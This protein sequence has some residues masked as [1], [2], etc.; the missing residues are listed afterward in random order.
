MLSA[1]SPLTTLESPRR[2]RRQDRHQKANDPGSLERVIVGEVLAQKFGRDLAEDQHDD[3]HHDRRDRRRDVCVP[4]QKGR[5][6]KR[7]DRRGGD[8]DNVVPDED[9]REEFFV[10]LLDPHDASG[11][12]VPVLRHRFHAGLVKTGECGFGS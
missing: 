8:V 3:R 10:M 6:Q 7:G 5:E 2:Q 12:F 9:R 4:L 1:G 11:F